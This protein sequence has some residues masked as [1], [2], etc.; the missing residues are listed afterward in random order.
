VVAKRND[1]M[2]Q[3]RDAI[4]SRDQ[5]A[6]DGHA[7]GVGAQNAIIDAIDKQLQNFGSPGQALT[8][9]TKP[10]QNPSFIGPPAP[11]SEP[12]QGGLGDKYKIERLYPG[13]P[14]GPAKPTTKEEYDA[15]P[16]G[17]LYIDP[18]DGKTHRKQGGQ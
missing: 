7:A 10:Q 15:L 18:D 2:A 1:L 13:G 5:A 4:K 9:A 12:A 17:S 11:V 8:D 16:A 3:R 6:K 14:P